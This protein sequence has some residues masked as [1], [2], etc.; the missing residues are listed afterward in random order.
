MGKIASGNGNGTENGT[1]KAVVPRLSLYL[2]HLEAMLKSG[3]ETVSSNQLGSALEMTDAQVRKDLAN[4]GQFGY[5]GIGYRVCELRDSIRAVLGTDRAWNVALIGVG[6]IGRALLGYAGFHDRGFH[7]VAAFDTNPDLIGHKIGDVQ[8][9]PLDT[10]VQKTAE[11]DLE[12]AA[13]AVPL[14]G[15][16]AAVAEVTKAGLAGILNFAPMQP[17]VPTEL[18]VVSVDLGQHFEQLAFQ[19]TKRRTAAPLEASA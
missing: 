5:P 4:F 9:F 14:A 16:D 11:F 2:R 1:P 18:S 6:N 19:V 8:V 15:L 7:I 3:N 12:L 13:L 17:R 10:L